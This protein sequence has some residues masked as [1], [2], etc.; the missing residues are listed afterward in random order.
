[1]KKNFILFGMIIIGILGVVFMPFDLEL[2]QSILVMSLILTIFAWVVDIPNKTISSLYLLIIFLIFGNT[3]AKAVLSFP[4][5]WN[6][7]LIIFSYVLSQGIIN[8]RL[9]EKLFQPFLSKYS[10][11]V[12]EFLAFMVLTI[13]VLVFTIP[14]PFSR[15]IL[16][17]MI[18]QSYFDE[19][20]LD[21]KTR[22]VIMLGIFA[23]NVIVHIFF[24]RGDIV[25]NN[26]ILAVANVEMSE[27]VWMKTLMV[28]AM[29]MLVLAMIAF[30]IVFKKELALFKGNADKVQK[31]ELNKEDK[32]NLSIIMVVIILWA[33]ENIHHIN[34]AIVVFLGLVLMYIRKIIDKEDFKAINFEVLIFLTAAFSI[35]RV[36]EGSGI[37]AK[38]F[39]GLSPYVPSTFS[40]KFVWIVSLST[41]ALHMVLGS[42]VTTMSVAI[43]SFISIVGPG[44]D[45]AVIMVLVFISIVTQYL[46]PVHN[47][48]II[49]GVGNK[50]YTNREVFVLGVA[51]TVVTFISLFF[52]YIPWWRF[53]GLI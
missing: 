34:G 2:N 26:G 51:L 27:F 52:F 17:A 48:L 13:I 44:V 22:D 25:L 21:K 42:S 12:Y 1:M 9:A 7:L 39:G 41:M 14:Q 6:F 29:G 20:N 45:P 10:R 32:I 47:S 28:P 3:P 37:A 8:S 19:I 38:I 5:S 50:Y 23:T 31:I 49:V 43:P 4:L 46:L 24:K 53:I 30:V 40:M 18:Y 16:L 36:M 15:V 35:G 33:T 11:N